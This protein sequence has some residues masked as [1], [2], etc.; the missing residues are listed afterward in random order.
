MRTC[1][2]CRAVVP[3]DELVRIVVDGP[4]IV[5]DRH[6]APIRVAGVRRRPGRGAYVHPV[7]ACVTVS[8]LARSL[9]RTISG[10]DVQT[11][12]AELSPARDNSQS[13]A[14]SAGD[15]SENPGDLNPGLTGDITVETTP[16]I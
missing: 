9:R 8:G 10:S 12:V 14:G 1:T 2:G 11:I 5:V 6:S 16:R 3:Q 15:P 4:R 13:T 7:A